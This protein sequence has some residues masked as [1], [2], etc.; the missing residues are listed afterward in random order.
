MQ[1]NELRPGACW[2]WRRWSRCCALTIVMCLCAKYP[3][4]DSYSHLICTTIGTSICSM[5][6]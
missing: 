6:W 2:P 4:I 5:S 1:D 3:L